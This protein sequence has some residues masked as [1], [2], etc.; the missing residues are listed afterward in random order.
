MSRE[1]I[2][3]AL[4]D[5]FRQNTRERLTEMHALLERLRTSPDSETLRDVERHFHGLAG[6]GGTYGYA[7]ITSLSQEGESMCG[8]TAPPELDFDR[9]S[10]ILTTIA[11]AIEDVPDSE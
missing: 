9:L 6:L 8:S 2:L 10:G 4:R 5:E 1:D 11:E 7:T 3:R